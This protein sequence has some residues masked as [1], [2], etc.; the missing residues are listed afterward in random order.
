MQRFTI[1]LDDKLAEEFDAWIAGHAYANRSEAVRD[2]DRL[3]SSVQVPLDHDYRL[4]NAR[5]AGE[6]T[7]DATRRLRICTCGRRIEA[8]RDRA[9]SMA[10]KPRHVA[11]A[12]PLTSW[13]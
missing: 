7:R 5:R 9:A 3:V 6:S 10:V 8:A 12:H 11:A 13:R 2:H 1:S 4:D